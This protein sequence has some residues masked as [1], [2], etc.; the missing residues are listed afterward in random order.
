MHAAR[1]LAEPNCRQRGGSE[2][3]HPH[4]PLQ[5][6]PYLAR[7][8]SRLANAHD[9]LDRAVWAAYG[10]AEATDPILARMLALNLERA[11]E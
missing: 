6:A 9:T 11:A 10:C 1:L 2:E 4:S 7:Q 5:P 3:A 8:R